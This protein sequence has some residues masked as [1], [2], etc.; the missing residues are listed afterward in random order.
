MP[1]KFNQFNE[2][3]HEPEAITP[4]EAWRLV[5]END[6]ED[7]HLSAYAKHINP[8]IAEILSLFFRFEIIE[9]HRNKPIFVTKFGRNYLSYLSSRVP[10]D[11][12]YGREGAN[13]GESHC[14]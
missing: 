10:R 13:G 2:P 3:S 4:E 8:E 1:E 6:N 11:G 12:L 5:K 14:R 7:D 9:Y